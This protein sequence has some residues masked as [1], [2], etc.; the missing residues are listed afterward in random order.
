M[1][2][3]YDPMEWKYDRMEWKYDRMEERYDPMEERYD[4]MEHGYNPMECKSRLD[5]I[6]VQNAPPYSIYLSSHL[7]T[8]ARTLFC[9]GVHILYS[10]LFWPSRLQR[11]LTYL[12]LQGGL[13]RMKGLTS[14]ILKK[15]LDPTQN[16]K[17]WFWILTNN[18]F[19]QRQNAPFQNLVT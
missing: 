13:C 7:S 5:C 6:F 1:E 19:N 12:F 11:P 14:R 10:L 17:E 4:P 18:N 16:L 15:G 9:H 2:E 8:R 3:R